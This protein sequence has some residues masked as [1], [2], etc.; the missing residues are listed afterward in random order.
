MRNF[1]YKF[2]RGGQSGDL[3]LNGNGLYKIFP[4][5]QSTLVLC[6]VDTANILRKHMYGVLA[7]KLLFIPRISA[8][9]LR[10]T[11][12]NTFRDMSVMTVYNR[13]TMR[14][15]EHHIPAMERF[16]VF[17]YMQPPSDMTTRGEMFFP[18]FN[19]VVC[20]TGY[21]GYC[22]CRKP[23]IFVDETTRYC[24]TCKKYLVTR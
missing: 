20:I 15:W 9:N 10:L 13:E 11:D 18:D 17:N 7:Y 1:R 12:G 21:E 16:I 14:Q 24:Q 5:D 19:N 22:T 4:L 2:L 3:K 8:L 23:T 6:S